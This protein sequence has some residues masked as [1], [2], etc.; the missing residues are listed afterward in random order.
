MDLVLVPT[1]EIQLLTNRQFLL[2]S[3][4]STSGNCGLASIFSESSLGALNFVTYG[5]NRFSQLLFQRKFRLTA[6]IWAGILH[7]S[8]S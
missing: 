6:C 1:S 2:T 3:T 5:L 8:S 4:F 7:T